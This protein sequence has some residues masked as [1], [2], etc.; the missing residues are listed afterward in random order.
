[1]ALVTAKTSLPI[2][3]N[4]LSISFLQPQSSVK[5]VDG[6]VHS[7]SVPFTILAQPTRGFYR[8]TCRGEVVIVKPGET[9]LVPANTEVTFEHHG[10][11][12]TPMSARWVHI[13]WT[14]FGSVDLSSLLDMPLKV[15]PEANG[16][17]GKAI[18]ELVNLAVA[19][20][21]LAIADLS[22]RNRL[23]FSLLEAVL[24]CST[25]REEIGS[26]IARTEQL[27]PVFE[28]IQMHLS[29]HLTISDL[30]RAAC[31]SESRFFVLFKE[32]MSISPMEFLRNQRLAEACRLLLSTG[33]PVG[34][35]AG[36]TGFV[37]QFH[38]SRIFKKA[39][40][41][42]PREYRELSQ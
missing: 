31:L 19:P 6:W 5:L 21:P 28:F 27:H 34:R 26:Y 29:E 33:R 22:K 39:F 10:P 30:A 42:G 24:S 12:G 14:L 36:D 7:K 1:M 4:A 13:N 20:G 15:P 18:E 38:F 35:I 9:A 41:V 16:R 25:Q 2:P 3:A 23:G 37:S 8:I 11:N 40:G 32:K 17:I